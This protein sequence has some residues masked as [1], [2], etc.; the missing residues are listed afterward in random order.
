MHIKAWLEINIMICKFS[1]HDLYC[2]DTYVMLKIEITEVIAS[3][4]ATI[5]IFLSFSFFFFFFFFFFYFNFM[6]WP[7]FLKDHLDQDRPYGFECANLFPPHTYYL[8]QG[9]EAWNYVYLL[10][11]KL[12]VCHGVVT[13][14]CSWL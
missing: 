14:W 12:R 8:N 7:P 10:F 3:A 5:T 4:C 1:M 11:S 2:I 9:I 13:S 6:E